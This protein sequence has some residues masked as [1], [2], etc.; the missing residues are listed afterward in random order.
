MCSI[1]QM[2]LSFS[3]H[4]GIRTVMLNISGL[5]L[6]FKRG[7]MFV[8]EKNSVTR[9]TH[10]LLRTPKCHT[11]AV[12]EILPFHTAY[13]CPPASVGAPSDAAQSSAN[14]DKKMCYRKHW[15]LAFN[16]TIYVEFVNRHQRKSPFSQQSNSWSKMCSRHCRKLQKPPKV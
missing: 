16:G 5:S 2:Q 3:S 6:A 1:L 8:I 13:I 7:Q 15:H 11:C 9:R 10:W 4:M 12:L 14:K